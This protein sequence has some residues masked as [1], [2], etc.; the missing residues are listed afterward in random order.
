MRFWVLFI[1]AFG[2][3]PARGAEFC[4]DENLVVDLETRWDFA[5]PLLLELPLPTHRGGQLYPTKATLRL[6]HD[7]KPDLLGVFEFPRRPSEVGLPYNLYR[8]QIQVGRDDEPDRQL[9]DQDYTQG[10]TGAGVSL[11]PG[12]QLSLNPIP[13]TRHSDGSPRGD[14]AV[15]LRFWGK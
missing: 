5:A 15:H 12:N 10:C 13:L 3:F 6:T 2:A 7:Q 11:W 8:L 14:E 9:I 1:V 4:E